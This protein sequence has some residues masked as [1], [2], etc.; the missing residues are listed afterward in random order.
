M[1][2]T[3]DVRESVRVGN[4][5][6]EGKLPTPV[7]CV[8]P[9]LPW[10]IDLRFLVHEVHQ[11]G[12]C[13]LHSR[14]ELGLGIRAGRIVADGCAI[15]EADQSNENI[16]SPDAVLAD[17]Q[18]RQRCCRR[19][20][21]LRDDVTSR[22]TAT[23]AAATHERPRG[24]SASSCVW[25]R[26]MRHGPEPSRMRASEKAVPPGTL[27]T[28]APMRAFPDGSSLLASTR[29]APTVS[30]RSSSR[31][32]PRCA[33]TIPPLTSPYRLTLGTNRSD[34]RLSCATTQS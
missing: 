2:W 26:N 3:L 34:L 24:N 30:K 9:E 14:V 25:L 13:G 17:V 18:R 20:P 7:L 6:A 15:A 31:P 8:R 23:L 12:Y 11:S 28:P 10:K 5:L 19:G 16:A 22:S 21:H 27:A 29:D 4:P 33:D 1:A 32:G